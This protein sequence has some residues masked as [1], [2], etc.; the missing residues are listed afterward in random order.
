M[1]NQNWDY[2]R[3]EVAELCARLLAEGVTAQQLRVALSIRAQE[4][5]IEEVGRE[6]AATVFRCIANSI[7]DYDAPDPHLDDAEDMRPS[8]TIIEGGGGSKV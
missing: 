1:V 6:H 5:T 2:A 8:L 7:E 4:M 3:A